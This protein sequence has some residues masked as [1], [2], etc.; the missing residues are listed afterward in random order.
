MKLFVAIAMIIAQTGSAA[1]SAET[2]FIGVGLQLRAEGQAIVI[3]SI[4]PDSPAALQKGVHDGDRIIA[5]AQDK[6]PA[7]QVTNIMQAGRLIRGPKG[8]T[9]H[10]TIVPAG[11]DDSHVRVVSFL[12]DKLQPPWGDGQLLPTGTKAPDIDLVEVANN[13]PERLSSYAGKIVVL[14]FWATWCAPCQRKMAD[15]Q[16]Y[17]ERYPEWGTNV[18]IIAASIDYSA[19]AAAKHVNAKGWSHTHNVLVTLPAIRAYHVGAIPTVYVI[20]RHDKIIA[21]NPPDVPDVVNQA[22]KNE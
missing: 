1:V 9:V 2:G 11:E 15:L 4:L 12:R 16:T 5:V 20:D 18:T 8:T 3:N 7:V 22:L 21:A 10:L 17:R 19:D 13:T 14:E 6:E